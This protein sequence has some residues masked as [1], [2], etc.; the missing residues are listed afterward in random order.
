MP[1]ADFEEYQIIY[2]GTLFTSKDIFLPFAKRA[3]EYM[4]A[5]TFDRL[6]KGVPEEFSAKVKK[7]CCALAENLFYYDAKLK[8]DAAVSGGNTASETIG[9][10]SITYRNALDSL[11]ALTGGRSF[12]EYQYDTAL[13]YLGNTGLMFRGVK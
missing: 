7:C 9:K 3:S 10:Y 13:M 12:E 4:D 2:T 1:Y 6:E 8:P 5:V 11:S